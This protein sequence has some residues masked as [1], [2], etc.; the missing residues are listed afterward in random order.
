[1]VVMHIFLGIIPSVIC[2]ELV[3]EPLLMGYI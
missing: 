3:E 1:M 2:Y